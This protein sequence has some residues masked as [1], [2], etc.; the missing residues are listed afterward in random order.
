[1][2]T[3]RRLWLIS[4]LSLAASAFPLAAQRPSA[5]ARTAQS[6]AVLRIYL[7]RHGQTDWNAEGRTQGSIDTK[8]N[9]KGRE[10]AAELRTRLADVHLDAVYSSTLSRSR[11]T[12][13]IARGSTPLTALPSLAE[14]QFGKFQGRLTSDPVTGPEYRKR[15]WVPDDALD[16]GESLNIF[17]ERVKGAIDTVRKQHPSGT[18][19]V[20]GHSNTNQIV[21]KILMGL[22]IDEARSFGQ[23]NEELYMIELSTAAPRIWKFI[24]KANLKDL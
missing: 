16:G 2:R 9:A 12:A 24:T 14:R 11:E 21:L 1:M 4:V 20:V 3:N 6:N 18:V 15:Q 13:E 19:L 5:T 7:A 10:Q 22:S 17:T 8:L 23:D